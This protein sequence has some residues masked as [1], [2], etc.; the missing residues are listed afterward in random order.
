MNAPSPRHD[1][2]DA[3]L[4]AIAETL[5]EMKAICLEALSG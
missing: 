5:R 2:I 4:E 3:L 1:P